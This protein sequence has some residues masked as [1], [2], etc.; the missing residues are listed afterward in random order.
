MKIL[1]AIIVVAVLAGGYYIIG[2]GQKITE[3]T[4]K[5]TAATATEIATQKTK[6]VVTDS[7]AQAIEA[8]KEVIEQT[9][10]EVMDKGKEVVENTVEKA[11][12]QAKETVGNAVVEAGEKV[13]GEQ[14]SGAGTFE[15]YSAEKIAASGGAVIDFAADWCPSC[16]AFERDVESNKQDI[17][18]GLTILRA[19]FDTEL[20]LRKKYG[21]TQQHTFVQVDASGEEITKWVG[22]PTLESLLSKVQ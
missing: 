9:T 8:G 12:D 22:S 1:L 19:D 2:N 14:G 13:L 18:Q 6:E 5:E 20:D 21:V 7:G 17:P 10:E 3:E 11:T 4:A 16:R 15:D